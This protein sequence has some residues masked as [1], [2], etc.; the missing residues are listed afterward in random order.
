MPRCSACST[1]EDVWRCR[2]CN[3][4]YCRECTQMLP[5]DE[6]RHGEPDLRPTN[7]YWTPGGWDDQDKF[8]KST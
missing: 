5:D 8:R 3:E 1:T 4:F 7:A 6:C 2:V